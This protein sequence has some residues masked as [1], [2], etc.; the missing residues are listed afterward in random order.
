LLVNAEA[1]ALLGL[2][3]GSDDRNAANV[4]R[5]PRGDLAIAQLTFDEPLDPNLVELERGRLLR[6]ATLP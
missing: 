1:D 3:I 6:R 5:W 2:V 4:P